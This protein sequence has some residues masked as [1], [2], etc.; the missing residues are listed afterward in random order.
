MMKKQNCEALESVPSIMA[1]LNVMI[2]NIFREMA[3]AIANAVAEEHGLDFSL[4][5]L[6]KV[7]A[8]LHQAKQQKKKEKEMLAEVLGYYVGEV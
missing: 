3:G 1:E 7:D 6:D 2:T 8:L 5:S 4:K